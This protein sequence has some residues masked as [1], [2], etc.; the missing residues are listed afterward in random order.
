M[1]VYT[2]ELKNEYPNLRGGKLECILMDYPM[3]GEDT[4]G[5]C[6]PALVVVPGGGYRYT[7]EREAAPIA[8][9]F[10]ARGFQSFVLYYTTAGEGGEPY[11][12][13]LLELASAVDYIKK[14]AKELHVNPDEVFA[15]GFSAG[16]HLA[17]NLAVEH[18]AMTEKFGVTLDCKP[19]A[20]GLS[21]PVISQKYGHIGSYE[22]LFWGYTEEAKQELAK[23]FPLDEMVNE[24]TSP[25]FIW[26]TANDGVVPAENAL[27]YALALAK[28]KIPYELHVY[29]NGPHG[30][31][32]CRLE[33]NNEVAGRLKAARWIDD[34]AEFFRKYT[35]EKF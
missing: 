9:E 8:S 13:Q 2:V 32:T 23:A 3:D 5:W 19:T 18:H 11:P 24:Q 20:V 17:G 6:R 15:V 14:H 7:S 27:Q 12:E 31:S 21:Y 30:L 1:K 33:I 16:G 26:A 10:F 34:C 28:Q 22:N 35:V 29:P 25:A 4:I